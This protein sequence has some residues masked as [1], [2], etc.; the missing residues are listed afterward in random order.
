MDFGSPFGGF[1]NSGIGRE[2]GPEAF[3][4]YTEF[5]SIVLPRRKS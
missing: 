2:G 1:K 4:A 3:E 5:Q